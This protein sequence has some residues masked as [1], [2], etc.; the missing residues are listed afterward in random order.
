[1]ATNSNFNLSKTTK[2]IA[3][4]ILD[5]TARSIFLKSMI[6]AESSYISARSKKFVD[7]ASSQKSREAPKE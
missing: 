7:P 3:S 1:M 4:T 5:K 2:R 6:D